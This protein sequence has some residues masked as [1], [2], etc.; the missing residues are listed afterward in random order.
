MTVF[1]VR[2]CMHVPTIMGS[3]SASIVKLW[4][5]Q[6]KSSR[7]SLLSRAFCLRDFCS[8][9][10]LFYPNGVGM[11]LQFISKFDVYC[12]LTSIFQYFC[13]VYQFLLNTN[14]RGTIHYLIFCNPNEESVVK[15]LTY[16]LNYDL[17]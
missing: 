14:C 13:E 15:Y 4:V 3:A 17:V 1:F 8:K 16:D 5:H 2:L 6:L 12:L 7:L 9:A 11:G 10:A